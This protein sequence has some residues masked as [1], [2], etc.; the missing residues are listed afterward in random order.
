MDSLN[1]FWRKDWT[2]VTLSYTIHN[3]KKEASD[4]RGNS[5]SSVPFKK[6]LYDTEVIKCHPTELSK[7]L[8]IEIQVLFFQ[9]PFKVKYYLVISCL[10]IN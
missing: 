8:T 9:L 4:K 10:S 1:K 7:V 6:M 3:W 5:F 2:K